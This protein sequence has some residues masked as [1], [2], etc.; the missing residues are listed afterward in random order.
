[1]SFEIF[2]SSDIRRSKRK[3][4]VRWERVGPRY[5]SWSWGFTVGW[6]RVNIIKWKRERES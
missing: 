3:G 1:M 6:K 4:M 5:T 2:G